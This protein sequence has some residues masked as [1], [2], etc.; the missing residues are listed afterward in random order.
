M[1]GF[2]VNLSATA[3]ALLSILREGEAAP[4]NGDGVR[5]DEQ[6][7]CL[8]R[9]S[10]SSPRGHSVKLCLARSAVQTCTTYSRSLLKRLRPNE[11]GD[12]FG[13]PSVR[14]GARQPWCFLACAP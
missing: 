6:A 10:G 4:G 3:A 9:A 7:K 2:R 1:N 8:V 13:E 14:P 5:R 11:D 12:S